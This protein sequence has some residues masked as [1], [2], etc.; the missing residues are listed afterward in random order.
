MDDQKVQFIGNPCGHHGSYTFY[1]AFKFNQGNNCRILTLGE[2]FFV[3][4]FSE[5]PV[6]ISELQLLWE[7]KNNS[8]LL[9][10]VR[11]YYLPEHTPEGKQE[12][13][14]Q[15]EVLAVSEKI[16]LKLED[17]VSLIKDGVSWET[18]SVPFQD[19]TTD[20]DND[21]QPVNL[22][23]SFAANNFGLK[24][25]GHNEN[26]V[27]DGGPTDST[28]VTILSYPRYCRYRAVMKRL[29]KCED[30][31]LRN[32]LVCAIGGF[33]VKNSNSR[34]VFCR[35]T[36]DDPELD[37]L[38]IRCDHL[39]PNLKGRPRKK[40]VLSKKESSQDSD[41]CESNGDLFVPPSGCRSKPSPLNVRTRKDS[42]KNGALLTDKKD[43]TK[44]EEAFL[45]SLHKYMRSRKTPIERIPSLGFKQIDIYVFYTY[46]QKLGGYDQS[47]FDMITQKR[48]WKHLYDQLGGN[49][50][51]TSAATCTR[52]HYERLLLPYERHK[53]GEEDELLTKS[54]SVNSASGKNEN[55]EGDTKTVKTDPDSQE[56]HKHK[57]I[58]QTG[59]SRGSPVSEHQSLSLTPS[60]WRQCQTSADR[61]VCK[62][63]TRRAELHED[64]LQK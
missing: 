35:D 12:F 41:S 46:A 21:K 3:K 32:A 26:D 14:G 56:N 57:K 8:Q 33:T 48:L 34:V 61:T 63:E 58:K 49:P 4:I 52:R 42:H 51:S 50:G 5:A 64:S 60:G 47:M 53:N 15:D 62:Q 23:K 43:I 36:F 17:L 37:N 24:F 20:S 40:R 27:V 2:F 19:T 31:W 9:S 30:Q 29:E 13:H 54:S 10:S 6:C 45:Q 1:K 39:A 7:D 55:H 18:G 16:I 25:K 38:E 44:E 11:L 59:T 22:A 28:Q